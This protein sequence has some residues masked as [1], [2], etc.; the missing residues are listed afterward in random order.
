MI[1]QTTF[2]ALLSLAAASQAVIGASGSINWTQSGSDYTYDITLNNTG[3]TTIGT[4]WYAW[5]PGEDYLPVAPSSHSGPA[6]WAFLQS[7]SPGFGYGLRWVA[8]VG[9]ELAPG[10][11]ISGFQFT[12]TTTPAE[13]AGNTPFGTHPPMGTSFVYEKAPF[14][15]QSLQFRINPVPEPTTM[16]GL[17]LGCVA[18]TRR[19]R[20]RR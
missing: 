11:S 16:L 5:I 15:G 10:S 6:G 13:L 12:T 2:F 17:S 4:L 7:T 19:A 14:S 20:R 8:P 18:L 9:S 1:K 3:T